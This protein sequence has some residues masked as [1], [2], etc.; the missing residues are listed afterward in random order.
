MGETFRLVPLLCNKW[1]YNIVLSQINPNLCTTVGLS[2]E[3]RKNKERKWSF[4][5][6]YR[7]LV[8]LT[9]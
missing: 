7:V 9:A 3:K 4:F 8:S 2:M 1:I 5:F 6:I